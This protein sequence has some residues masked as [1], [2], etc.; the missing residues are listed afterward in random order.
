MYGSSINIVL[1]CHCYYHLSSKNSASLTFGQPFTQIVSFLMRSVLFKAS[2]S[3]NP[4]FFFQSY[5]RMQMH[6]SFRAFSD[7]IKS[8]MHHVA[9]L[10]QSVRLGD[11]ESPA[12]NLTRKPSSQRLMDIVY[13]SYSLQ[14]SCREVTELASSSLQNMRDSFIQHLFQT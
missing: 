4:D 5:L 1:A 3:E 10:I 7:S 11:Q 13:L 14:L 8:K 9:Q 6:R 2:S 12:L